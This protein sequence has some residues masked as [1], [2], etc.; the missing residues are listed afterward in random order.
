MPTS[1]FPTISYGAANRVAAA[2]QRVDVGGVEEVDPALGGRVHDRAA[3]GL[4]ALQ[5]E[6]HG[7]EAEARNGK[8]GAAEL[9]SLHDA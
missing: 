5:A 3:D 6:G 9:G 1:Q 7:A 2:A 4:L 8:A